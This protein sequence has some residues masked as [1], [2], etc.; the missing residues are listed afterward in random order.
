M[1]PTARIATAPSR[2]HSIVRGRRKKRPSFTARQV[3]QLADDLTGHR[4]RELLNFARH[5]RSAPASGEPTLDTG[6]DLISVGPEHARQRRRRALWLALGG[7]MAL[8]A[9]W[10]FV[11]VRPPQQFPR[12]EPPLVALGAPE[13]VK[14]PAATSYVVQPG[15]TLGVIATRTLGGSARWRDIWQA[16][17]QLADPS[18]IAVG[19]TLIIPA[20]K[21]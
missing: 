13:V 16:N 10:L 9:C 6:F 15:D 17:P 21:D 19:Q 8:A 11:S 7:S 20:S 3:Q 1:N 5:L 18:H 14:K 12:A 4:K 2:L